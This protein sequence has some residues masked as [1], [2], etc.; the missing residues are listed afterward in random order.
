MLYIVKTRMPTNED[1]SKDCPIIATD[2]DKYENALY[3]LKVNISELGAIKSISV[4]N[5]ELHIESDLDEN[6][7]KDTIKKLFQDV[8]C[9]LRFVS[10]TAH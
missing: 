10:I 7:L 6:A 8:F 3:Q 5:N 9:D 4:Y 2:F 1:I